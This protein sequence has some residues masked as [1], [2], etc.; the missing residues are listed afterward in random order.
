MPSPLRVALIV[1]V[2]VA[3]TTAGRRGGRWLA[4]RALCGLRL[5]G[6]LCGL[7]LVR[8]RFGSLLCPAPAGLLQLSAGAADVR[9]QPLCLPAG[10]PHAASG[11]PAAAARAEPLRAPAEQP[12]KQHDGPTGAI[13][14]PSTA[15]SQPLRG[16][17]R[18]R[19]DPGRV[20]CPS[21]DHLPSQA[22]AAAVGAINGLAFPRS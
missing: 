7:G 4:G 21:T 9:L 5:L 15:D 11:G 13:R 16:P 6:W 14:L 22:F 17:K 19:A 3:G 10:H 2:L 18:R 8:D 12:A 20:E 1:A